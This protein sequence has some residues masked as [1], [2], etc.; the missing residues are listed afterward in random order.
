M[1]LI[2]RAPGPEITSYDSADGHV[3][4]FDWY[5]EQDAGDVKS[6]AQLRGI[7]V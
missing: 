3:E 6:L 5:L 7:L 1:Q 2:N 4:Q